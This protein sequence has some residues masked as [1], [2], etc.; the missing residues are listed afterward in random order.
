MF[1]QHLDADGDARSS[2]VEGGLVDVRAPLRPA[3]GPR[4]GPGARHLLEHPG[5]VLAAQRLLGAG[6]RLGAQHPLGGQGEP[7]TPKAW[8]TAGG[9]PSVTVT[10]TSTPN[11]ATI[12]A[13]SSGISCLARCQPDTSS[14]RSVP[15]ICPP[16]DRVGHRPAWIEPHISDTPLRGS[17]RR[18]STSWAV[19][20]SAPSAPMMSCGQLRPGRVPAG[21][22]RVMCTWSTAEVIGPVLEG[23]LTDVGPRIAVQRVDLGQ[24]LHHPAVDG[25]QRAAGADLLGR[26]E[27]QPDAAGQ[28][29]RSRS[30]AS[31]S[32]RRSGSRCARRARRRDRR[33]GSA[34]GTAR[35]CRR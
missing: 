25:V 2:T 28:Q 16:R 24:V 20:A 6:E 9:T 22:V 35:P 33:R 4:A 32:Q 26:L 12:S 8:L 15:T 1:G 34:S 5:E 27:D 14:A 13:A 30:R 29:V 23:Q 7:P 21:P 31:T 10:S 3:V 19:V 11:G 17:T 18:D